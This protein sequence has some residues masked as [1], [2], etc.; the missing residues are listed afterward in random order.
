MGPFSRSGGAEACPLHMLPA[1]AAC[2]GLFG[3]VHCAPGFMV[4]GVGSPLVAGGSALRPWAPPPACP[5]IVG[6]PLNHAAPVPPE[7]GSASRPWRPV[8]GLH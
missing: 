4:A 8:K 2:A 7:C 3:A 1:H 5:Q 6:V